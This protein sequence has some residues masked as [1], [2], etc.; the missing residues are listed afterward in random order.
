MKKIKGEPDEV[1]MEDFFSTENKFHDTYP[2]GL[3]VPDRPEVIF[4]KSTYDPMPGA[5]I[6]ELQDTGP[7]GS[8]KVT[9]NPIDAEFLILD[10]KG[11]EVSFGRTTPSI[12]VTDVDVGNYSYVIRM[13]GYQDYTGNIDVV[14]NQICCIDINLQEQTKN[15]QC[16]IEP[17]QPS[18]PV[19]PQSQ[20]GYVVIREREFY[21][22]LGLLIGIVLGAI[23]ANW[24]L[25]KRD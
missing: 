1:P 3:K 6:R 12:T 5:E 20:P 23:L 19:I 25:K 15:Q 13:A 24:L 21:G 4:P 10:D 14:E 7:T 22:G 17:P 9:T 11:Q 18:G 8:I 16:N 2:K